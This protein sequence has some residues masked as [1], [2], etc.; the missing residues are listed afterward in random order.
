MLGMSGRMKKLKEYVDDKIDEIFINVPQT[1]KVNPLMRPLYFVTAVFAIHA[2]FSTMNIP[3]QHTPENLADYI[4]M[5]TIGVSGKSSMAYIA[6]ESELSLVSGTRYPLTSYMY[7][8]IKR[9]K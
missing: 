1:R 6:L 7:D 8:R 4:R 9:R 2:L 5:Y 3:V